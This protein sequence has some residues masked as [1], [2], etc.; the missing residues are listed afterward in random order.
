MI[1]EFSVSNYGSIRNRVTLDLRIAGTAP[2]LTCFRPSAA[3]PGVRLP[4]VA[5]LL[6]PNAAGKSTL[7][8]ALVDFLRIASRLDDS[9]TIIPFLTEETQRKDTRF[10]LEGEW[11]VLAPDAPPQLFRYELELGWEEAESGPTDLF[12][13]REALFHFPKGRRRRL[14]ERHDGE[15]RIYVSP[16]FDLKPRD[17][18]LRAIRRGASVVAT[19]AWLNVPLAARIAERMRGWVYTTN[20]HGPDVLSMRTQTLIDW[21]EKYPESHHWV[22]RQLRSSDL[23]IGDME[24]FDPGLAGVGKYIR[25]THDGLAA[26]ILLDY[27][28]TGT[29]R[30]LHLLP[31]IKLALDQTGLVILDEIDGD[32][33]VDIVGELLRLF[34]SRESNPRDAQLLLT[35]HHVGLLDDLE[36]EEVFIVEKNDSGATRMHGLRDVRGLRRDVRL[37]P[38]YRVGAL[39]GLPRPG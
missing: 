34:R 12:V 17:D 10:S 15:K 35:S 19:L 36:K 39:G 18:R 9:V 13:R 29:R 37:Y 14:F 32:L 22:E 4:A 5:V 21:L 16:E 1:H 20:I 31:S 23:G 25:F 33:H 7:L 26:P 8:R 24:I 28:S 11:D 38:K 6:G 27:E 2:D 30:L 3:K